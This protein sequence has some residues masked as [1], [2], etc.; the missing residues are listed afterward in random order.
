MI[1]IDRSSTKII[2]QGYF[3]FASF[4]MLTDEIN[5]PVDKREER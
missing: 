4:S 2:Y 5:C 1:S 3:S